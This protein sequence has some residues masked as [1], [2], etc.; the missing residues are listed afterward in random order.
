MNL[1]SRHYEPSICDMSLRRFWS[2]PYLIVAK[3][4]SADATV[5]NGKQSD[6]SFFQEKFLIHNVCLLL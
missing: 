6:R 4:Q 5:T 2:L 1:P 3:S